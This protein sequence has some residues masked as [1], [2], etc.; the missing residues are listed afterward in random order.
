MRTP[1]K[2][3]YERD[4]EEARSMSFDRS[5]DGCKALGEMIIQHLEGHTSYIMISPDDMEELMEEG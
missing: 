5:P 1:V 3:F 4:G 2:I